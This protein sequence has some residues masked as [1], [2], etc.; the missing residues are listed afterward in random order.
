[1][2]VTY[3]SDEPVECEGRGGVVGAVVEGRDLVVLPLL[4]ALLEECLARRVE[5]PN[6]L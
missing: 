6:R 3:E 4:V 5:G 1:M 2:E